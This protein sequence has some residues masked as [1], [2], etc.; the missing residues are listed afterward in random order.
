MFLLV[1]FHINIKMLKRPNRPFISLFYKEKINNSINSLVFGNFGFFSNKHVFLSKESIEASR[2]V[3]SKIIKKRRSIK[4][5]LLKQKG[6]LLSRLMFKVPITKKGTKSRMG[7]G[8]G[9]ISTHFSCV[10]KGDCIFE[11]KN[12]PFV[13]AFKILKKISFKLGIP[14]YLITKDGIRYNI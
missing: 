12:V 2:I 3:I 13:I 5:S 11:L 14:L 7:K 1:W 10:K 6:D 8:K 4:G 9:A